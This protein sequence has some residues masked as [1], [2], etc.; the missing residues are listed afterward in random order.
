M[1]KRGQT[2]SPHT[3]ILRDM[4]ARALV[5]G[6]RSCPTFSKV[7]AMNLGHAV[8]CQSK[9]AQYCQ[10]RKEKDI[11]LH[12]FSSSNKMNLKLRFLF[13][14]FGFCQEIKEILAVSPV[15]NCN[16]CSD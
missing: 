5:E 14:L 6:V 9:F 11:L 12:H 16:Y 2:V 1:P 4:F 7:T 10:A 3:S 15:I 13:F 8:L